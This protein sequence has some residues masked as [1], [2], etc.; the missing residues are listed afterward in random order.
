MVL[1]IYFIRHG[2]SEAN[3]AKHLIGGRSP[4]AK[5]TKLG[6]EQAQKL[7]N[8]FQSKHIIPTKVFSSPYIRALDTAKITLKTLSDSSKIIQDELLVELSQGDWEGQERNSIYTHD[9][10]K[11]ITSEGTFFTPPNGESQD[12]VRKRAAE[13]LAKLKNITTNETIFVFGHG[14]FFRMM[15]YEILKY[16]PHFI[17]NQDWE[18]TAF[19]EFNYVN[20]NFK[21]ISINSTPHL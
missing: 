17:Y 6:E 1:T 9:I 13:F 16:N 10:L 18:N 21:L 14:Y 3:H 4:F 5:L 15:T 12:D 2:Y 20:N 7:G 8:Y 19:A 11:K